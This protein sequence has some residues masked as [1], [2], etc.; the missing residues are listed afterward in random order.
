MNRL[1]AVFFCKLLWYKYTT[2]PL[3]ET[4][5]YIQYSYIIMRLGWC[6][7]SNCW[8]INYSPAATKCKL[9]LYKMQV[10]AVSYY[11]PATKLQQFYFIH[12]DNILEPIHSFI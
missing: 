4:N 8:L 6:T 9:A 7:K 5:S 3:F 10:N 1:E 2:L 11:N 12:S